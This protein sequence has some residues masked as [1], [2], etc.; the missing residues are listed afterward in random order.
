MRARSGPSIRG[1]VPVESTIVLVSAILSSS[2]ETIA[3]YHLKCEID[4]SKAESLR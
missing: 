3:Q 1:I 2:L 4:V